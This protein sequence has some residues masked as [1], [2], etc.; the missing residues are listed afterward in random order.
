[1]SVDWRLKLGGPFYFYTEWPNNLQIIPPTQISG[2]HSTPWETLFSHLTKQEWNKRSE[3]SDPRSLSR[4]QPEPTCLL[5]PLP[6]TLPHRDM[7]K[8]DSSIL[9]MHA[10]WRCDKGW[11][12]THCSLT[13]Q[14]AHLTEVSL[15]TQ[16]YNTL[17][18][19]LF[20]PNSILSFHYETIFNVKYLKCSNV[21]INHYYM[22]AL[23]V[24]LL[25]FLHKSLKI[26]NQVKCSL[27][28][29]AW[30]TELLPS[31]RRKRGNEE[32]GRW[33]QQSRE[34][35]RVSS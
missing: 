7:V 31:H 1:M 29:C 9:A 33:R 28:Q 34:R 26:W 27:I 6:P 13:P 25:F 5:G 10:T 17:G 14:L 16:F 30:D 22:K 24:S 11:L 2:S 15:D 18:V 23:S 8:P 35:G 3:V 32:G 12:P 20:L 21:S 19:S 4:R